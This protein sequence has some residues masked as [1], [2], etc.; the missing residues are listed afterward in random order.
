MNQNN[1]EIKIP[2]A[3]YFFLTLVV[4]GLVVLFFWAKYFTLDIL[5]IASGEVAPQGE[6]KF[7]QHLEGGI[8][9]NILVKEGDI[10]QINQPIIEL[11]STASGADIGEVEVRIGFLIIE[12]QRLKA[13]I[14]NK[15]ILIFNK[16][17]E[18]EIPK[19]IENARN[20]H[21][22]IILRYK[23][24][25]STLDETIKQKYQ[26][27]KEVKS[28]IKNLEINLEYLNEQINISKKLLKDELTNRYAHLDLLRKHIEVKTKLDSINEIIK[29]SNSEVKLAKEQLKTY[30]QQF[31]EE[32]E[33]KL[34]L[35]QQELSQLDKR[36]FKFKD[37]QSR[38]V[39]KSPVAGVIKKLHVH[40]I[41][42][43][44]KAGNTIVEIVPNDNNLI[45]E[46][47]LEPQDIGY[48]QVGQYAY[49]RLASS[50]AMRFDKL[51]GKVTYV[52]PDTFTNDRGISFYKVQIQTNQNFFK[53]KGL[54]CALVPGMQV[55]ANIN[56][57]QRTIIDYLLDPFKSGTSMALTEK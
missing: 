7:I 23:S 17:L 50:D 39:I 14:S 37:K 13:Q 12:I 24:Q 27:I 54:N 1:D 2:K 10:V 22:T 42:G 19:M 35:A 55:T 3:T 16:K 5:S 33:Q 34:K 53:S 8:V 44:I 40:T 49:V 26:D 20:L 9:K 11:E 41:G 18:Q 38:T 36:H 4:I 21:K 43:V 32:A 30:K 29:K 6:I 57:G 51:D 47:L 56:I 25:I 46:A 28:R 45:I 31:I 48:V 15:D 52:S